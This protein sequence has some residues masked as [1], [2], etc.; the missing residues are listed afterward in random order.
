M[1]MMHCS[2]STLFT[3]HI[4]PTLTIFLSLKIQAGSIKS[5]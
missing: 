4:F 1:P 3:V 2:N 5:S